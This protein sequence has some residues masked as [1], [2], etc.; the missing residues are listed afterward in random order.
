MKLNLDGI[1]DTSAWAGYHL[2]KYD[3]R[4]MCLAT[5]KEPKW[6]HF[7]SGNIFRAFLCVSAQRLLEKGCETTGI[8]CA[9][10]HGAELITECFRP[11]DNLAVAVTLNSDGRIDKEVVASIGESLTTA[12]DMSRIE[13]IFCA[14]SLQMVSFTITEK[15]YAIRGSNGEL[16]PQIKEDMEAGPEGCK[17]LM[18][19][20]AALCL[21]RCHSCGRPLALVSMDN[22]SHNGEK[23]ET[24]V[25]EIAAAWREKGYIDDQELQYLKKKISYPW[26]MIDKITPRPDARVEE[27]LASDGIKDIKP[28]VTPGGVY[29]A[30]FVNAERPQYLVIEDD[31]PNGRPALEEAGI[32]FTDRDTV[33][34]VEKMKVCTCLNPLHTALAVFGCL[35]GHTSIAAE[36]Q[37]P[38]LKALVTKMAYEEG[39][40]VVVNPGII[41]PGEFLEEVLTERFPNPFL[42]DTPQRIA[43]DTSQKLP[44][45]FGETIKAHL[46]RGTAG[47]LRLIPLVLAG[48]LRYLLAVDD[49]GEVFTPSSDPLLAEC[50]EKLRGIS[51]RDTVS[52][53]ALRPLLENRVIFGVDLFEAGLAEKVT[54]YFNEMIQGPG[55]VLAALKRR[56]GAA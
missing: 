46:E 23:I 42:P 24:A 41:D 47:S 6:L 37:Q 14:P 8:I 19:L 21:K 13:E 15:G 9:E 50:Q 26:S 28:F 38:E 32:L 49:K 11:H 54:A 35:L 7:G 39:M 12:D 55:S 16:L 22:C 52:V 20:L 56:I 43:T 31:F 44:I 53:E 29:A 51:L 3:I 25:T 2:P 48:W 34:S 45:R 4:Q 40:P 1:K 36:M 33:N 18:A 10:S 30:P 17:H 27:Q 5:A